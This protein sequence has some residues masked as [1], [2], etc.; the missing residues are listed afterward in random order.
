MM[1][2]IKE[3]SEKYNHKVIPDQNSIAF[4][5]MFTESIANSIFFIKFVFSSLFSALRVSNDEC[6]CFCCSCLQ[7]S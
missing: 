1:M 2:G 7:K 6:Y 4:M 5:L 3:R